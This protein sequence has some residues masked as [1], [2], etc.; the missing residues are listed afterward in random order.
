MTIL[1]L[2]ECQDK[3]VIWTSGFFIWFWKSI[4]NC[5]CCILPGLGVWTLISRQRKV[6]G[7]SV[8]CQMR[9]QMPLTLSTSCAH[10]T[11]MRE[12]LPSRQYDT[13]TS[14][15]SGENTWKL[16]LLFNK[17]HLLLIR[18]HMLD[19]VLQTYYQHMELWKRIFKE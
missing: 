7:L 13:Y 11:L 9:Q 6:Q 1:D 12:W 16:G 17:P 5:Y 19:I 14:K 2:M 10:M 8:C 15:S 4:I 3:Y 18:F